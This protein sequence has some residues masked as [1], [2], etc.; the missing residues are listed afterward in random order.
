[1]VPGEFMD[2]PELSSATYL[3]KIERAAAGFLVPP[4]HHVLQTPPQPLPTALLSGKYMFVCQDASIPS[5]TPLYPGPYL[6]L[7]R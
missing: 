3:G 7:E 5:L 1:M 6:V 2:S 4:P